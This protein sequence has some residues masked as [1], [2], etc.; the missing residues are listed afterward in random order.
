MQDR[1]KRNVSA[2]KNF[3]NRFSACGQKRYGVWNFVRF[4]K[5][6]A[7]YGH[8]D[9]SRYVFCRLCNAEIKPV[10]VKWDFFMKIF[11]NE[12]QTERQKEK[13]Y[14]IKH[15]GERKQAEIEIKR[16]RLDFSPVMHEFPAEKIKN[17]K[18]EQD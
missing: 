10:F 14:C 3:Q 5:L 16:I 13:S 12:I 6:H 1:N 4:E 8:P 15:N 18:D 2:C 7:G 9:F 11:Q 17:R